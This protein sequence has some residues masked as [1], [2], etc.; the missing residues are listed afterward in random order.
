MVKKDIKKMSKH[1]LSKHN[2][3]CDEF[4]CELCNELGNRLNVEDKKYEETNTTLNRV[5][6]QD[7]I[8]TDINLDEIQKMVDKT[9]EDESLSLLHQMKI[10][11]DDL[12]TAVYGIEDTLQ[13]HVSAHLDEE[14]DYNSIPITEFR[15]TIDE[16]QLETISDMVADKLL[17]R[18]LATE[19]RLVA[20]TG[21]RKT[22]VAKKD[23][24]E[25]DN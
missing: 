11:I 15:I 18:S 24:K 14:R 20:F 8:I 6:D 23:G 17:K 22:L 25:S 4:E 12:S 19:Y 7:E 16:S 21:K 1:E 9:I 3:D 2:Q 10:S 5:E 13:D